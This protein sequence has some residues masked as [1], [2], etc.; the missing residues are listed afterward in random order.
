[1]AWDYLLEG[2]YDSFPD[3]VPARIRTKA[4]GRAPITL[5]AEALEL[6]AIRVDLPDDELVDFENGWPEGR[7]PVGALRPATG[8]V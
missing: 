1:M 6:R 2:G 4:V 3:R 8:D 5:G 7:R